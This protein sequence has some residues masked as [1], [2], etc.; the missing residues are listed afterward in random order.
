MTAKPSGGC[1][2]SGWFSLFIGMGKIYERIAGALGKLARRNAPEALASDSQ[3]L[4]LLFGK[5]TYRTTYAMRLSAVYRCVTCISDA[6]AQLPLELYEIDA[7]GY[8][9]KARRHP[10]FRVLGSK[11]NARMNRYTWVSLMVQSMLLEGAGFSWIRRDAS[12]RPVEFV[13][14]PASLVTVSRPASL[15]EPV[16][17][18]IQGFGPVKA[19]DLICVLNQT[20]DGVVGVSTLAYASR[21]LELADGSEQHAKNF[22]TSGCS[23]AGIL[24]SRTMLN[25]RQ[26]REAKESW[27]A[28]FTS[29]G[30]EPG[31]VA[32]LSCD[33]DFQPVTVNARDA[34]LLETRQF[35]V[36]DICRFFGVSPVKA[37]DLTHSS[38]STVEATNI[39][40]LTDTVQPLLQKIELELETKVF[41]G[42][43]IDV[44][45]DVSQLLRA[46]KQSLAQY[47]STMFQIGAISPNEIRREIDLEPAEGGDSNFVQVNLQPL[48]SA[49]SAPEPPQQTNP[50]T[51]Q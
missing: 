14:V 43:D 38:Y 47:Y 19:R 21:T 7:D 2:L 30:G 25:E 35:N 34:Q 26:K 41:E 37:F 22:F 5:S 12:G 4:G 29:R 9:R 48:A 6:V 44:R 11:P 13:Y 49:A 20:E 40:F 36:V 51:Q 39:S 15:A 45:F 27:Q 1:F 32:V 16:A 50:Q 28:A 10:L 8:R 18:N 42:E 24:K 23:V 3:G 17:Y 31:G 33:W 46:D